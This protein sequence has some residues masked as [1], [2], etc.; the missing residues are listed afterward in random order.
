[1]DVP[2]QEDIA[3]TTALRR[4]AFCVL[5]LDEAASGDEIRRAWRRQC[6]RTH[7][8][9]NPEDPDAHRKFNLAN[10]AYRLLMDGTPC[11][12][13]LQEPVRPTVSSGEEHYVLNNR[14][15][16]CLWWRERFF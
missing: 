6:M 16:V 14:W 5:G 13:L 3:R 2:F 12:E 4:R 1:M 7:P 9:R 8:D 15:G 10:C 11:N